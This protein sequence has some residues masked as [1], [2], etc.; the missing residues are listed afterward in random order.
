MMSR[1]SKVVKQYPLIAFFVLTIALSWW[2]LIVYAFDPSFP[3]PLLPFG[4]LLA[5]VI[6]T[7]FTSGKAALKALLSRMVR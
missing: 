7:A 6:V 2:P 3:A 1:L 4:P 5:A